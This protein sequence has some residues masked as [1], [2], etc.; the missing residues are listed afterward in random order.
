MTKYL[1]LKDLRT[2]VADCSEYSDDTPVLI[3]TK[4]IETQDMPD[5]IYSHRLAD[6]FRYVP[7]EY[8]ERYMP[9]HEKNGAIELILMGASE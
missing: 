9:A 7:A 8:V 5:A 4:E 6:N 2:I 1:T 3:A